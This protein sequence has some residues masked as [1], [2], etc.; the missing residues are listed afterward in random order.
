[1]EDRLCRDH[2][3]VPRGLQHRVPTTGAMPSFQVHL[4]VEPVNVGRHL[5]PLPTCLRGKKS[6]KQLRITF[7]QAEF[8]SQSGLTVYS[9]VR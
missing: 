8:V 3:H 6:Y 9:P 4:G 1:M 2:R 5:W 7:K